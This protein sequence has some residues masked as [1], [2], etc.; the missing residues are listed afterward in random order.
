VTTAEAIAQLL[1]VPNTTLDGWVWETRKVDR[2]G[3]IM[4]APER[5]AAKE[6]VA[7][8]KAFRGYEYHEPYATEIC[9]SVNVDLDAGVVAT[10]LASEVDL[11]RPAHLLACAHAL[12]NDAR[13]LFK[14]A[15]DGIVKR[16]LGGPAR[17]RFGRQAGGGMA[18]YCSSFQPPTQRSLAAARLA[19]AGVGADLAQGARR[20]IDFA[21]QDGGKQAGERLPATIAV[22]E[23]R[24]A[25]GW[26]LVHPDPRID[27]YELGLLSWHDGVSFEE[28]LAVL[29][30]GRARTK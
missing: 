2:A 11:K 5:D 17:L 16:A 21:T 27:Q 24:Y 8:Y 1:A 13:A 14:N 18:R 20:W 30:R 10:V 29:A 12:I 15:P 26:R 25:E 9:A 23:S 6:I 3:T 19:L 4:L 7:A 28:A 22:L